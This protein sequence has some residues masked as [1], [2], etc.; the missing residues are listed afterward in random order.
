MNLLKRNKSFSLSTATQKLRGDRSWSPLSL[1]LFRFFLFGCD[2][3]FHGFDQL[4]ELFLAFLSCLGVYVLGDAFAVDSRREPTFVEVVVYHRHATRSTLSY[5]GL[6][7]LKNRFCG[8]FGAWLGTY[9]G[10][11]RFG[12]FC[13]CTADL[14]VDSHRRLLLHG[15]CD[16]AVDVQC[17]FRAYV[18]YHSGECLDIHAVFECHRCEGVAQIVKSYQRK[19]CV[20]Q[21]YL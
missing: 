4:G 19:L 18:T 7:R 15:V 6:V 2:F 3:G 14:S 5:L 11:R 10:R 17:C 9:L 20:L 8:V 16:M 12:H 21:Y 1:C 13:A